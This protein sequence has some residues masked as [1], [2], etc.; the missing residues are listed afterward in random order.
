MCPGIVIRT[1]SLP[2][3]D[4][5]RLFLQLLRA[6]LFKKVAGA[7][8]KVPVQ[9]IQTY[10][11]HPGKGAAAVQPVNGTSLSLTGSMFDLLDGIYARSEQECDI[12][13]IF[14]SAGGTLVAI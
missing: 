9:H 12:D 3:L 10:L 6:K 5:I 8:G 14:K 2:S 4:V 1:G 11:V 13:I 7:G